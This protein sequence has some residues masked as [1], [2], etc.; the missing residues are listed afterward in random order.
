MSQMHVQYLGELRNEA[1]HF[2]GN[3]L[4][5]DAP[6]DNHGKGEAF[7]PTDLLCTALTTCMITIMGIEA[8]KWNVTFENIEA[9]YTKY[10]ASNPRRVAKIEIIIWLSKDIENNVH[11]E[12]IEKA[13]LNCPVALSIHPD[14]EQ[15]VT[16]KYR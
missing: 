9:D 14:I 16:F 5:T 15:V 10:M 3:K 4:I 1:T 13:G 7:S 6:L 12:K 11:R 2:S 8:R